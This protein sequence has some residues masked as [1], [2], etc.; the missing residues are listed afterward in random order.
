MRKANLSMTEKSSLYNHIDEELV[1]FMQFEN[2]TLTNRQEQG[3]EFKNCYFENI[4]CE[5]VNFENS[6][7]MDIIFKNCDLSNVK[8]YSCL[9]RRVEFV[10]CKLMGTD[11]S[12]SV[13][14]YVCRGCLLL[15]LCSC[16]A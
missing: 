2:E 13:Y 6:Y 16:L 14:D 1:Q 10:N 15:W 4:V 11:F 5:D 9:F 12:E 7:F 3:K 8:F